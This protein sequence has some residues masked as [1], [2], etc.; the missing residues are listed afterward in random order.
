VTDSESKVPLLPEDQF[1][2]ISGLSPKALRQYEKNGFVKPVKDSQGT[3][4]YSEES[5]ELVKAMMMCQAGRCANLQEAYKIAFQG[6]SSKKRRSGGAHSDKFQMMD[7][8]EIKTHPRFKGLFKIDDDLMESIRTEMVVGG[9]YASQPIVLGT[10]P[11]QEEPVLI[12]GHTRRRAAIAAGIKEVLVVIEELADEDGALQYVANVQTKRRPTDD[13]VRYQLITELD[14]LMDR[15]G[16]RR[17]SQAKSKGP[18]GPVET[19]YSTSAERTAALVGCSS[20][21]VKRARRVRKEGTPE[22]LA[23][24]KKRKI[25]INQ[26]DKLIASEGKTDKRNV[27]SSVANDKEAM[28]RLT[29]KNLMALKELSG[30]LHFLVNKAVEEFVARHREQDSTVEIERPEEQTMESVLADAD[31]EPPQ[32]F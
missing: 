31:G 15:G 23:D 1:L 17:S 12:D 8:K 2:I 3:N 5:A 9:Y 7:P 18:H 29:D 32:D 11:G 10:W 6:M 20:R 26:A 16:D 25:S 22:I 14:K 13:W 4:Y 24:L 28:V 30:N 27:N 19:S 21:T